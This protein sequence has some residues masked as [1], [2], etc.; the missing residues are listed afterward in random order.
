MP[1]IP[2]GKRFLRDASNSYV[3]LGCMDLPYA[4]CMPWRVFKTILPSLNTT[5][6]DRKTYWH[7]HLTESAP[8]VY[9]IILPKEGR[10]LDI[11]EYRLAIPV[12]R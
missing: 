2:S 4:F 12:V 8:G 7:I 9:G 1:F 5:T 6:T 10:S 11:G 3:A